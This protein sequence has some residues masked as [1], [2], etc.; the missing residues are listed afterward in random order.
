[1]ESCINSLRAKPIKLF[2]FSFGILK[3]W[4]LILVRNWV[5]YS[6]MSD[7][8]SAEE[9]KKAAVR[10]PTRI[11]ERNK[12]GVQLL[13]VCMIFLTL[14]IIFRGLAERKEKARIAT[15]AREPNIAKR[16][17]SSTSSAPTA[18]S[19]GLENVFMVYPPVFGPS[20]AVDEVIS[21]SG[22]ET[23]SVIEAAS[24]T[25]PSCQVL[26]MQYDFAYS[27]GQPFVGMSPDN[28]F[29]SCANNSCQANIPRHRANSIG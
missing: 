18:T 19:T 20:G 26:L 13:F 25:S 3:S 12:L 6:T 16:A 15:T 11:S 1:M 29:M 2:H 22:Q 9:R 17:I 10:K 27:Y 23:A 14:R 21:S 7:N 28:G 8:A 5:L 24:A 4:G